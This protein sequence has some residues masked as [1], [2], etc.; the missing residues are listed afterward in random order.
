ML[1]KCLVKSVF[2]ITRLAYSRRVSRFAVLPCVFAPM[3][4][5]PRFDALGSVW[6][7]QKAHERPTA[8]EHT[9]KGA[10]T[11]AAFGVYLAYLLLLCVGQHAAAVCESFK[12]YRLCFGVWFHESSGITVVSV[13]LFGC[14]LG[15]PPLE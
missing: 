14:S 5:E 6:I 3:R 2:V 7:D 12:W 1:V 15:S 9:S 8:A 11:D 13:F 4:L 10:R